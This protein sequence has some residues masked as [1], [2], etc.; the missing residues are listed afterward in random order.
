[1]IEK[2]EML[3][4]IEELIQDDEMPD[5]E[6]RQTAID[7]ILKLDDKLV[8]DSLLENIAKMNPTEKLKIPLKDR[9]VTTMMLDPEI[10]E[11]VYKVRKGI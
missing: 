3:E 2:T 5:E 9:P 4:D 7:K 10:V 11:M 6:F 8:R 1:L